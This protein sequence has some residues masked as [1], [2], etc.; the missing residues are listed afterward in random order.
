VSPA[1]EGTGKSARLTTAKNAAM[2]TTALQN[3][4]ADPKRIGGWGRGLR[5]A[6]LPED[7]SFSKSQSMPARLRRA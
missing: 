6:G 7:P 4:S 5:C 1:A 3:E 2:P